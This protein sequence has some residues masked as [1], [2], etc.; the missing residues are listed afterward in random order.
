MVQRC[1]TARSAILYLKMGWSLNRACR[2]AMRD[3][4]RLT[5]PRPASVHL[6][7]IDAR[8]RHTAMTT[9]T[10]RQ[11]T[12]VYHTSRMREPIVKPR[13]VVPLPSFVPARERPGANGG[14]HGGPCARFPR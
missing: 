11:V 12:Y 10:G 7:A 2:E 5:V 13:L 8:G 4:R 1:N 3:L 6:V 14:Y 9:E